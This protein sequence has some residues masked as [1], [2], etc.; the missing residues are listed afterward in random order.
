MGMSA[1][2]ASFLLA[3]IVG[4]MIASF[5]RRCEC[6]MQIPCRSQ[7]PRASR[8]TQSLPSHTEPPTAHL[9]QVFVRLDAS[10]DIDGVSPEQFVRF[11]LEV[12]HPDYPLT[13]FH[14]LVKHAAS[15]TTGHLLLVL[16][17]MPSS[18]HSRFLPFPCVHAFLPLFTQ[19]KEA[20]AAT[21]LQA[22][23]RGKKLRKRGGA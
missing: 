4:N 7:P 23:A 18:V 15:Q 3:P 17:P 2:R 13:P 22:L 10:D 6:L 19:A 9:P 14:H 21:A 8:A 5:S 1:W 16:L 11:F 20:A 12:L